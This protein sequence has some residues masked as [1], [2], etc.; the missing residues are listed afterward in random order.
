M[1]RRA[2][3]QLHTMISVGREDISDTHLVADILDLEHCFLF[4]FTCTVSIWTSRPETVRNPYSIVVFLARLGSWVT[5]NLIH[6]PL[7]S[8]TTVIASSEHQKSAYLLG[9]L[10]GLLSDGF[11][12]PVA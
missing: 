2:C 12:T 8:T 6:L 9:L 4:V 5:L 7:A 1:S 11:D 3:C 10:C